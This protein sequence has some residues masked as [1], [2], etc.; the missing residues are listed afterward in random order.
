MKKN[1]KYLLVGLFF[2]LI[3]PAITDAATISLDGS[4]NNNSAEY[5][6]IYT[7]DENPISESVS[8]QINT[9]N[10]DLIY[11][12]VLSEDS[13]LI[14]KDSC[15]NLKCTYLNFQNVPSGTIIGVLKITNNT[16]SD[17][18]TEIVLNFNNIEN[19]KKELTLAKM[20]TTTSTT[21][22]QRVLSR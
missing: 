10:D 3:F 14:G 17:Q 4:K 15:N 16:E 20:I 19:A 2:T 22:T 8:L 11:Q 6:L 12:L 5:N 21:T 9:T 18:P 7:A 13:G 1:F